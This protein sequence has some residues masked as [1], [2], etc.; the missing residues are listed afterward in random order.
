MSD[1]YVS[2]IVCTYN[3]AKYLDETLQS[4]L[5]QSYRDYEII[6]VNGPSTDHTE[7]VLNKYSGL[8]IVRQPELN[9][10]SFAR[11]LGI[12]ASNGDILA[13]IDDDAV[14]DRDWL[15]F[16]VQGYKDDSVG[17]V[18]GYV[19]GPKNEPLFDNGRINKNG[20][21]I[22]MPDYTVPLGQDEFQ[23]SLGTNCS[24]RRKA[25]YDA[26]GFDP[27]FRYYH[28]ESDLCV[29]IAKKGY[30]IVY[31]KDAV[32]MH[33]MAEG[34]NRKS[35]YD[36][37]WT[38]ILKNIVYFT[39]RN[40]GNEY[41]AWLMPIT[42]LRKHLGDMNWLYSSKQISLRKLA[43]LYW[44]HILGVI[45]GYKDGLIRRGCKDNLSGVDISR[46]FMLKICL[47]S[48]EFSRNC[49]GGICKYTYELAHSLA[50]LGHEV[51]VIT[52][53]GRE[54]DYDS[55]DGHV[56]VHHV[57][58]ADIEFARIPADMNASR[59][60][61]AQS[62]AFAQ[63]IRD[64]VDARGI[65]VVE[66]PLWDA[67]GFAFSLVKDVPLCVRL[68]TP[69][70]KVAQYH[71]WKMGED[72]VFVDFM[73]GEAARRANRV[74]K[75]SNDI[76]RVIGEH[77]SIDPEKMDL[78]PLGIAMP[79]ANQISYSRKNAGNLKVLFVGRLEA[80]KG[81]DTLFKAIPA[82][83]NAIPGTE[84]VLA[85]KDTNLSPE[86]GSYKEYLL[87]HL[88][89]KYARNVKFH[90]FVETG[91]LEEMYRECDLF[92][93]PS[94]YE[95]F[96]LIYVEAMSW[97]KPVIGC[98]AGGI[99]EVFSD[100]E[101]GILIEPG[102]DRELAEG[103]IR[104]L[105]D[106]GLRERMGRSARELVEKKFS[107]RAMAINTVEIYRSTIEAFSSQVAR[108]EIICQN[109]HGATTT[110]ATT[111]FRAI[112]DGRSR[113]LKI[114]YFSPLPPV[115]SGISDYSENLLPYL[116]QYS[117]ID[118]FVDDFT[119]TLNDALKKCP[120][121]SYRQFESMAADGCYDMIIYHMG[122]S[123]YHAYMYPL[124]EKY[125]GIIVMHDYIL[126]GLVYA[127]TALKGDNS[128]YVEEMKFSHGSAGEREAQKNLKS[129]TPESVYD[130]R[131]PINRRVLYRSKGILVHNSWTER[132]VHDQVG[133]IPV[134]CVLLGAET[135]S[136]VPADSRAEL[137]SSLDIE[138]AA[139]VFG[140]YGYIAPTK[141]II[142]S[143][144]AFARLVR[145]LPDSRYLLVGE[146]NE[147]YR[148]EILRFI[149]ENHLEQHV[150][151][152]GYVNPE[153]MGRY[154]SITDVGINLRYPVTGE[155]SATL[156]TMI[157][158]GIPVIVSK[159]SN[160]A[161]FPDDICP[162]VEVN[163]LEVDTLFALMKQLSFNADLRRHMGAMA[164]KFAEEHLS[165][166]IV[167]R[168]Y[169]DFIGRLRSNE[170]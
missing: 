19:Y 11:N 84:F 46:Y 148:D 44:M 62:Y 45:Y 137:R 93:A 52:R 139:V 95:S 63:K 134:K 9:G 105:G 100:D 103:I 21:P 126:H 75:I 50:E 125:P 31:V 88:D 110:P 39:L 26:G 73:E 54:E 154:L 41:M 156:V 116:L 55:I 38:M 94:L 98:R 58:P 68:M 169:I 5:C 4:L 65:Q 47:T 91:Q 142:S 133:Y 34:H 70:Y 36:I 108:S 61:L 159:V 143:L 60:V 14:A 71:S 90:G 56:Y 43:K 53:S 2:V 104:I 145:E 119:P 15:K 29:R 57:T 151:L 27:Y 109:S 146:L 13:F 158:K 167:A 96:G 165:F 20:L 141:R 6:V 127:M 72:L 7:Q 78:C 86:G 33:W 3:R 24:F 140:S 10:L 92:V 77:H 149:K 144:K 121:Y 97:G 150:I 122:N 163:D 82:V 164:K 128:Q 23:I 42:A 136:E 48:G 66:M 162:K 99:P 113:K 124:I 152:T 16:L 117:D 161:D 35:P 59:F 118:L 153:D 64:L 67:E 166:D 157:G 87:K 80:R 130:I 69:M 102:N 89:S 170:V 106:D 12:V 32:V 83:V 101:T 129:L 51:H 132:M 168:E 79:P 49:G 147:G 76:G 155:M 107:A 120:I 111:L 115:K 74:I 18:G 160:F 17:G 135:G 22:N 30:R 112:S 85:G 138:D 40:F 81:V 114:A 8:K 1:P 131:F 123:I 28:D 25:V 37:N